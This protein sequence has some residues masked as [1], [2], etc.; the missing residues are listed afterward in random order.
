[1]AKVLYKQGLKAT[2]LGLAGRSEN[3]LY[4]CTDTR[5]LFK[6]D[7]LYTDG[8]RK[9][10]SFD[11]LPA[12]DAAAD[13]KLYICEDTGNGYVLNAARDGWDIVIH[14]VDGETIAYN[15]NGL[16]AVKAIPVSAVS[17]LED[18]LTN[19]EQSVIAGAKIATTEAAG[20]VKPNADEFAVAEDGGLTLAAVPISKVTGL[21]ERL[22]NIEQA[23]TGGVHYKGSVATFED[24]PTDAAQGDL[25]EVTADNSE[26]CWNGTAW[27][28]Y[29]SAS[30]LK[31]IARADLNE[32]QFS[33]DESN[34]LNL[35]AVDASIVDHNGT[36]LDVLL[37]EIEEALSWQS[38]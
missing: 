31:P 15:E 23:A 38:M 37:S 5:E 21:E 17:G 3:A 11:A 27:F 6:G 30:G 34:K 26:W 18:R 2:Y 9:A 13:G 1:M 22:G 35:I 8:V 28:E 7:D 12:F 14:G 25:Y 33:I 29:G 20:I 32:A 19:V 4:W 36:K 10:A 24:L 16:M